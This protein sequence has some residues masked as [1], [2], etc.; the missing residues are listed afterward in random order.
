MK[1]IFLFI[2]LAFLG[3]AI[4]AQNVGIGQWEAHLSYS[5]AISVAEGL[6]KVYCVSTSGV[7]VL[8]KADN[9]TERLSKVNGLSDVEATS[10]SFNSYNNKFIIVYNNSNLDIIQ[11]NS[12]INIADI[13][14]KSI[15]GNKSINSVYFIN[16]YAYLACGFGVVVLDMD[17]LEIKDTYYIGPNGNA[18][19]V[20]D[21]TADG[22]YIYAATNTGIYRALQNNPNLANFNAWS[23][24]TGIPNG[25]YNVIAEFGGKIYTNLSK[26][27]MNNSYNKDTIYVY[28]NTSWNYFFQPFG[29]QIYSLKKFGNRLV[30]VEENRVW[31]YDASVNVSNMIDTYL[32]NPAQPKY[33][34]VDNADNVWIADVWRGLI[35][36]E[37]PNF[38]YYYPN[39]PAS[40]SVSDIKVADG[41]VWVAPGAVNS[42]WSNLYNTDGISSYINGNWSVTRGNYPSIVNTDTVYDIIALAINPLNKNILYAASF[43]KGLLEIVNGTPSKLYAETNSSLQKLNIPNYYSC[44]ISGVTF[45][46]ANNLWVTNSGVPLSVSVKKTNGSW[47]ALD[48]SPIIGANPNL[49]QILVDK[50]DQKWVVITRGG[51]LMVYKGVTTAAPNSSNTKKL[52]TAVGNGALPSVGVYCLAEDEDGEIWVG[53]DKGI[54]VFYTP[55]NVFSGQ[56]FDAQQILLEQDGHVQ[57]LLETEIVQSIAVDAANRKW[58]ATANSGVYLMSPD[59]TKQIAHFDENN[60]PL[61]SNDVKTVAVNHQTGEVFFGTSKGILSYRGTATEGFE[62]FTDVYAF[63]NPV[64]HE[65]DGPIAIKGLIK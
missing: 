54:T 55:E 43:S 61:F 44:R 32:G 42:G 60:S 59:G 30:E 50:N 26:R 28:D 33:A 36:G 7:F 19:N 49:G 20:N 2:L 63:P 9:S 16:Q 56:N 23:K 38:F 6:G 57:I 10:V 4:R 27:L 24:M 29:Y 47:Q 52:T 34:V 51:G 65:Y 35:K 15:I 48:F 64:K 21:V 62:D 18:I 11:N 3:K 53:T 14:R 40:A 41:N 8:N 31:V 46:N 58:I 1:H 45:D 13:K 5:S 25:I 12:I 17:R 37:G 22:T 39:G